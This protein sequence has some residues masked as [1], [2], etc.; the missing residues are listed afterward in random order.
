MKKITFLFLM[1]ILIAPLHSQVKDTTDRRMVAFGLLPANEILIFH[2]D[3]S[4][5]IKRYL[6]KLGYIYNGNL[7]APK[8]DESVRG[9]DLFLSLSL[10]VGDRYRSEAF[11]AWVFAGPAF[12]LVYK[13]SLSNPSDR[14]ST[15]GLELKTLFMFRASKSAG[16]GV[17]CFGN[18]NK[19]KSF[20]GATISFVITN[21]N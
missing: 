10:D 7:F 11:E 1:M 21:G 14:T 8:K 20:F 3:H 13:G 6:Y 12:T 17:G 5:S 16:F 19:V 18:V 15:V 2:L 4:I 9:K